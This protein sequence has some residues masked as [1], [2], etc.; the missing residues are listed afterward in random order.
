MPLGQPLRNDP[1]GDS[2]N[3]QNRYREGE[4]A[5]Q[6]LAELQPLGVHTVVNAAWVSSKN[7]NVEPEVVKSLI[8]GQPDTG[9]R[10]RDH[11]AVEKSHSHD[12]ESQVSGDLHGAD[13]L[14]NLNQRVRQ[15]PERQQRLVDHRQLHLLARNQELRVDRFDQNEVEIAR[16]N[17]LTEVGTVRHEQD[18]DDRVDQHSRRHKGK[19]LRPRPVVNCVDVAV[20]DLEQRNLSTKP[21]RSRDHIDEE[22]AAKHHLTDE[23]VS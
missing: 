6:D 21:E 15:Q 4:G 19:I 23:R 3:Q 18:F 11:Q 7:G 14:P 13:R 22:I 1:S 2:N 5:L 12:N 9:T 20:N 10:Q 17:H 16:P 8:S